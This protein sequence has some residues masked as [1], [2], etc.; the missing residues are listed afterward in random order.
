MVEFID[1]CF[2]QGYSDFLGADVSEA[3]VLDDH[4][5]IEFHFNHLRNV[6]Q[7]IK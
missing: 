1:S 3:K 7:S 6:L 5:R 4:P 2:F